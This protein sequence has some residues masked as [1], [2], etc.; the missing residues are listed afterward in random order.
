MSQS[1]T[2]PPKIKY[3]AWRDGRPRFAPSKTLR[4]QGHQGADLRHEDGRWMSAGEALEWSLQFQRNL[5]QQA[6]KAKPRKRTPAA[7]IA[8]PLAPAYP[9]GKLF[10]EWLHPA[11]NPGIQDLAPKT[12]TEYRKKENT[13]RTYLPDA[14]EA[15]AE[16]F[17]KPIAVGMYDELR[18][19]TGLSQAVGTMRV[20]GIAFQWAIRKGRVNPEKPNPFHNLGM[21][22][23]APRIR[24]GSKE[25]IAQMVAVAD[26][27]GRPEIGDMIVL[28]VWNGQRQADR[29]NYEIAKRERGRITLRQRKTKAIVSMPEA[30]AVRQRLA[31]SEERRKQAEVISPYVI[32]DERRWVPLLSFHYAHVFA[33]IREAAARGLPATDEHPEIKPMPSLIGKP[34]PHNPGADDGALLA[35][36]DQDLRDTAVTWLAN[37]GCT[38]P[39]ICAITG[40]SMKTA[41]DILKHYLAMNPELADS[42]IA[43]MIAWYDGAEENEQ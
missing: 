27:L 32:L 21:K 14:W 34:D 2:P 33:E 37:S 5:R 25:E 39:E 15:E 7:A 40:H 8:V 26:R 43:K 12:V 31:A 19:H 38:I 3:V 29:L 22:T 36:R 24:V 10:Q 41:H 4:E 35:L 17:T 20:L 16:A 42:A 30:P 1:R 18:K 6:G 23:P 28:G 11:D 13:V 9:L